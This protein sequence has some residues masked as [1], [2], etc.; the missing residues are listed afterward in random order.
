MSFNDDFKKY[1]KR[2]LKLKDSFGEMTEEATKNAIIMPLLVLLGYDVFNPEEVIPEYTCDVAGKKGEKVDYAIVNDS[3]P[4]MLIEVKKAGMKLQKAQ[5]AQLFRYFSTNRCRIAVLTNGVNY[6]FFSDIN[7]AN[8][9]DDEPFFSFNIV[10]DDESVYI[11]SLEQF[12]KSNLNIKTILSKA[13]FLKYEK[14]VEKTI[15]EDLIS[16]TDEIVKYFL[17]RPE[18][19]T[20]TKITAQMIEKYREPTLNAMRKTLGIT[21]QNTTKSIVSEK[22]ISDAVEVSV[23]NTDVIEDTTVIEDSSSVQE[24]IPTVCQECIKFINEISS[25]YHT[26]YSIHNGTHCIMITSNDKLIGRLRISNASNIR[27]DF[28]KYNDTGYKLFLL[29][30]LSQVKE[31]L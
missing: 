13:V 22:P 8:I 17:K 3:E 1:K 26:E 29:T 25:N 23:P 27:Y 11:S 28:T 16:P 19:N 20:G 24:N 31:Y 5:Q 18:V 10:E 6:L 14:V 4:V 2:I 12:C 30:A 21:I 9:M 7:A 15:L